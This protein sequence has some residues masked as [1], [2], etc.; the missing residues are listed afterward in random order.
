MLLDLGPLGQQTLL[1][2]TLL[3]VG[4]LTLTYIAYTLTKVFLST[5][6]LPG[7]SVRGSFQNLLTRATD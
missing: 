4:A 6:V 7:V 5:L 1:S 3:S 2:T